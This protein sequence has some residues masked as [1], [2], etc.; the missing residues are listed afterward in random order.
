ML[1]PPRSRKPSDVSSS[2]EFDAV[3]AVDPEVIMSIEM[4]SGLTA[5]PSPAP[6]S[7][8]RTPVVPPPTSP[9]P[10]LTPVVA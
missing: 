2:P 4:L 8:V 6:I 9:C 3:L 7:I 5:I 1:H 10:A